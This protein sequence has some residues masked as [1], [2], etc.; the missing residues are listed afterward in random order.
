MVEHS[1]VNRRVPGSSPG[2]G[3]NSLDKAAVNSSADE[4]QSSSPG[5]GANSLDNAAVNSSVDEFQSSSP[6][7]GANSLDKAA[8]NSSA[9]EFQSSIPGRGANLLDKAAVNSSADESKESI[10]GER[11][12]SA[13][14]SIQFATYVLMNPAGKIYIGQTSDL[15]RRLFQ[16][17]DPEYR[18]TLHTKRHLG[19][20]NL[21]HQE[22]FSNRS[23]AMRRE[24][25]LKSSRGRKW[26][27]ERIQGG[28]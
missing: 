20:W 9:D 18:A 10:P 5:R 17:N 21:I 11:N 15:S 6:G 22:L 13:E 2:R 12:N 24:R 3:A 23:G 8:V 1:A 26:I 4:F 16:H 14:R 7:R 28:C 27:R 25:E 19:P